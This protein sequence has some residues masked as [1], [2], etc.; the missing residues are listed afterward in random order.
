MEELIYQMFILG[1]GEKLDI[2]LNKGL[3]GIIYFSR[4]IKSKTQFCNLVKQHS[5]VALIPPFLS[6]DQE[7]GKVERTEN[8][9]NRYLSPK[10]AY[11]KGE[12]FLEQQT[13]KIAKELKEYGLNLNFA[14]CAD[15]NTNPNNPIIGERAFSDNPQDVI[16]GMNIV[17]GIYRKNRIIPCI[18]HYP[19][20]GDADKDSHL[21]LPRISLDFN[22]MKDIHI[23]PFVA[24]VKNDIEMI[25]AAHLHCT[26]F[27]KNIIPASL[28]QNAIGYLRK[29]LNYN[30]IIISDDMVMNGVQEYGTLEAIILGIKAGLDMFIYREANK[31]IIDVIDKLVK[32]VNSDEKLKY[33]IL[34]SNKR[35]QLLKE[36][37][38]II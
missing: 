34:K 20:H 6:I 3:G 15:V 1:T 9:H 18:K 35:I 11:K 4:D 2:A 28:S 25:M 17:S 16:K 26:C 32:I 30:G 19:G 36:K 5:S 8:I 37:Y 23:A 12:Y 31:N 10:F 33:N 29:D 7:G 24:A 14:P 22:T 13:K 38:N 27:D 21:T